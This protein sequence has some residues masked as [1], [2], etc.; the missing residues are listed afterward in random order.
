[1]K[2]DL[3]LRNRE[4][5]DKVGVIVNEIAA[6]VRRRATV[7]ALPEIGVV[8]GQ[9]D[10]LICGSH[11]VVGG[12]AGKIDCPDL[13]VRAAG[14]YRQRHR[15]AKTKTFERHEPSPVLYCM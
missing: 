2:A 14:K 9:S 3:G 7:D 15:A 8:E 4:L 6:S 12:I 10:R 11:I 5:C 1:M 13:G